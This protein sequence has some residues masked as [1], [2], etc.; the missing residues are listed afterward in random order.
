MLHPLSAR[1]HGEDPE[2]RDAE[3]R[4]LDSLPPCLLIAKELPEKA[5][6]PE[7]LPHDG[8]RAPVGFEEEEGA[9]PVLWRAVELK[10]EDPIRLHSQAVEPAVPADIDLP[11]EG[12]A[13]APGSLRCQREHL[14]GRDEP[15]PLAASAGG[16]DGHHDPGDGEGVIQEDPGDVAFLRVPPDAA[17]LQSSFPLEQLRAAI[18]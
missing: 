4:P 10:A 18:P 16:L 13:Q 6:L 12:Q 15:H 5:R 11:A 7:A 1:R 2:V 17:S 8:H 3:V 14:L 9:L